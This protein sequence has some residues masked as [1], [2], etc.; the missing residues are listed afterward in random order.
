MAVALAG[1]GV[2]A[3]ATSEPGPLL[4]ARSHLPGHPRPRPDQPPSGGLTAAGL[5]R[6]RRSGPSV[7]DRRPG[8]TFRGGSPLPHYVTKVL[9]AYVADRL[10]V[11]LTADVPYPIAARLVP[12]AGLCPGTR[13]QLPP[14]RET[15]RLRSPARA[16]QACWINA[17][18]R[19][20]T[21]GGDAVRPAGGRLPAPGPGPGTE[22]RASGLVG[23]VRQAAVD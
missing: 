16:D 13:S 4:A 19:S 23:L 10:V 2:L 12:A 14:S 21:L 22:M 8:A 6:P 20:C 7:V 9:V 1:S 3:Q 18:L 5:S 17:R 15:F 11:T